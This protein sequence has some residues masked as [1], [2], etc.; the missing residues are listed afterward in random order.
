MGRR[1]TL[2]NIILSLRSV[3]ATRDF[4]WR[5]VR[6]LPDVVFV[7]GLVAIFCVKLCTSSAHG[8]RY[9]MHL[10]TGCGRGRKRGAFGS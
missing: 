4:G 5:K 2:Q 7:N 1:V 10:S 6:L 3:R 8:G 9:G